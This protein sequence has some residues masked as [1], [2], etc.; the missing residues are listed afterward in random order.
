[1]GRG[2][3]SSRL[4]GLGKRR[5]FPQRGLGQSPWPKRVLVHLEPV[6]FKGIFTGQ[7]YTQLP[8]PIFSPPLLSSLLIP[9]PP[10]SLS[11]REA[12]P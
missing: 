10:L 9:F 5:K 7:H 4:E 6:Y 1:M 12:A 11:R 8:S 3:L 2:H